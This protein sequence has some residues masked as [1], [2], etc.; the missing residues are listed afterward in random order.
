[1]KIAYA[2]PPYPGCAHLYKDHPDYAG[3]VDHIELGRILS[4]YDGWILHTSSPALY[5]VETAI[6]AF[7]K[8]DSYRRAAWTKTFAAFKRN[9]SVAYAWEPVLVSAA[10]KPV[11]KP[12]LTYRDWF[13][14]PITLKRGL[15]G[16]KPEKVCH[17]LFELV[18]AERDDELDDLFPGTG[19]VTRAW[20]SWKLSLPVAEVA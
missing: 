8:P 9:V 1:M 19:A 3:E 16:A 13:A 17:W 7:V 10:R 14:C 11:V 5:D 2:D 12:G 15:T 20:E 6:R 18:G 4:H